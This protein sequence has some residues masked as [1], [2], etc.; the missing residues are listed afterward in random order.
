MNMVFTNPETCG[1]IC[2]LMNRA[3]KE[4]G[5]PLHYAPVPYVS[6]KEWILARWILLPDGK[7]YFAGSV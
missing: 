7:R 3:A 5:L 4:Q 1:E 6:G 2:S